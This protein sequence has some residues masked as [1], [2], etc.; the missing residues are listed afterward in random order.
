MDLSKASLPPLYINGQLPHA[1]TNE[2]EI[3][4]LPPYYEKVFTSDTYA[5]LQSLYSKLY[6]NAN[7]VEVPKFYIFAKK[8]VL[9]GQGITSVHSPSETS[10]VILAD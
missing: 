2:D 3:K 5:H 6:P 1:L 8:V 9:C 10:N 4:T 7:I